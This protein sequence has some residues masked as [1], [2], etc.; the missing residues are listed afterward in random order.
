[1]CPKI[2][3]R[4]YR[5]DDT[6]WVCENHLSKPWSKPW[7]GFSKR[8]DACDCGAGE[9]CRVCNPSDK[10]HPPDMARTGARIDLDKN[11]SPD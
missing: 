6:G 10:D 5:C 2:H 9:P 11:G 1:M 7:A 4:L 3:A 8:R